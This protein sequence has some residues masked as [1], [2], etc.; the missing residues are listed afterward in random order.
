MLLASIV[1][2][3]LTI[4]TAGRS[5]IIYWL[6]DFF[7]LFSFFYRFMSPKL[8]RGIFIVVLIIGG[9]VGTMFVT[10]TIARFDGSDRGLDATSSIYGYAGQH[11]N[12]FCA[13]F[14][15]C[16]NSPFQIGRIF[17]LT[18]KI[19]TGKTFQLKTHYSEIESYVKPKV[20]VFDTFG[21]EIYLDLGWFG[22]LFFF[23]F[24]IIGS[25]YIKNRWKELQFWHVF[26]IVTLIAFYTRGLFAWPF[27]GHYT[28]VALI[29]MFSNCYFFK[30]IFKI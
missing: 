22:Y 28:T 5:A 19:L 25:L 7:L 3:I 12:N 29:F 26:L 18:N 24:F 15:A 23:I 27:T 20:H 14:E 13:V 2:A 1:Q 10:I 9:L 16:G 4:V 17:P 8:K 21:A 6:F 11:V 30:Y